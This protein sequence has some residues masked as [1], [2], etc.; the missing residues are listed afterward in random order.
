MRTNVR[1]HSQGLLQQKIEKNRRKNETL[2][3]VYSI[4]LGGLYGFTV[5]LTLIGT[6]NPHTNI[7]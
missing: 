6:V 3:G 7:L 4:Q 5:L 2:N 1:T